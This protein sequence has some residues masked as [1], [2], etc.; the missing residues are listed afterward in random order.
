MATGADKLW[1]YPR[2]L[3][4]LV[5]N[6]IPEVNSFAYTGSL[7]FKVLN[8]VRLKTDKKCATIPRRWRKVSPFRQIDH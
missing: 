8:S 2:L 1:A 5:Q 6:Y 7:D 4:P 3:H